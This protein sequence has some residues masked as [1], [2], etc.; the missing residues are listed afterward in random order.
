MA[1]LKMKIVMSEKK[2]ALVRNNSRL[3]SADEKIS[4]LEN[5]LSKTQ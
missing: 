2:N 3:D 1:L 5:K 4:Q